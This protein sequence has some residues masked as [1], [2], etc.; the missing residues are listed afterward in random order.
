M[1]RSQGVLYLDRYSFDLY[2]DLLAT[3][4]RFPFDPKVI[5]DYD[6][7]DKNGLVNEIK[8]FIQQ[9]NLQPITLVI[10][11]SADVLFTKQIT[12]SDPTKR[13]ATVQSFVENVPFESVGSVNIP[14]ADAIQIIA[15]NKDMYDTIQQSFAASRFSVVAVAPAVVI[16]DVN[17]SNGLT[18]DIAPQI[19]GMMESLQAYNFQTLPQTVQLETTKDETTTKSETKKNVRLFLLIGVFVLLLVALG[20]VIFLTNRG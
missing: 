14:S 15:S 19:L 9:N 4:I 12:L 7:I 11:L 10:I 18:A 1:A 5:R 16:N 20:V 2:S 8:L 17:F 13:Q 3:V 6:V